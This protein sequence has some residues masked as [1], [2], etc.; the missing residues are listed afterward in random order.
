[1]IPKVR[2]N[3]VVQIRLEYIIRLKWSAGMVGG[4]PGHQGGRGGG[5]RGGGVEHQGTLEGPASGHVA[6]AQARQAAATG[7]DHGAQQGEQGGVAVYAVAGELGH[8]APR[9]GEARVDA[10]GVGYVAD[11]AAEALA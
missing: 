9:K 8:H 2:T 7:R 11:I 6:D 3:I 4:V 10:V 1:M 5:R